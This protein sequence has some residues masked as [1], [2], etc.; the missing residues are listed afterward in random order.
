[1]KVVDDD[2][3]QSTTQVEPDETKKLKTIPRAA[4]SMVAVDKVIN[5]S[6][7]AFE[8]DIV[9]LDEKDLTHLC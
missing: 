6:F 4:M 7:R 1:V 3:N 9:E 5:D 8:P 2:E